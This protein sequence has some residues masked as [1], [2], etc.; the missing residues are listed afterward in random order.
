MPAPEIVP[1]LVAEAVAPAVE[2]VAPIAEPIVPLSPVAEGIDELE[3]DFEPLRMPADAEPLPPRKR[4]REEV[5]DE[6]HE[7]IGND[8]WMPP[9]AKRWQM[10]RGQGPVPVPNFDTFE[11]KTMDFEACSNHLKPTKHFNLPPAI[12]MTKMQCEQKIREL[13][14][15]YKMSLSR[16]AILQMR[17][18]VANGPARIRLLQL[19]IAEIERE[20]A[21]GKE[22]EELLQYCDTLRKLAGSR[23]VMRATASEA[24][25][26]GQE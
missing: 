5:W 24:R 26:L 9:E 12:V 25:L 4:C 7:A 21:I 14:R 15:Q 19:E 8:A 23:T 3:L 13:E 2:A 10:I 20:V 6:K 11:R 17:N 22:I 18:A 1:V 16:Q